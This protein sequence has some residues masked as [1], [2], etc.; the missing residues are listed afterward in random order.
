MKNGPNNHECFA[1][2][3]KTRVGREF[4]TAEIRKMMHSEW[5]D[6]SMGSVL[7]NDHAKGN[8]SP[9]WCVGTAN[10]IFDFLDR[11][12]YRVRPFSI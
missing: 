4:S 3:F 1:A 6:F 2:T 8:K 7:P 5:P 10:Q 9:C 11:G 12:R